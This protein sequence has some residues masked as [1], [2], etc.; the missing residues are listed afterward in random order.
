MSAISEFAEIETGLDGGT[1]ILDGAVLLQPVL[2][3]RNKTS[4]LRSELDIR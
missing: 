2:V 1:W 4:S 3:L